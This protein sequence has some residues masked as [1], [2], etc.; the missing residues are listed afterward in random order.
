[1]KG[2][3]SIQ[4]SLEVVRRTQSN[5]EPLETHTKVYDACPPLKVLI[6]GGNDDSYEYFKDMMIAPLHCNEDDLDPKK[7]TVFS[8]HQLA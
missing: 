4:V 8:C 3:Y 1:M 2:F 6:A 7:V 5:H